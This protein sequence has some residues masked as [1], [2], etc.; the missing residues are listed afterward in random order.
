M[1]V[2]TELVRESPV[3]G[4]AD[5]WRVLIEQTVSGGG[6][7]V[8]LRVSSIKSVERGDIS[9]RDDRSYGFRVPFL[10]PSDLVSLCGWNGRDRWALE[11]CG[12][13]ML[14]RRGVMVAGLIQEDLPALWRVSK[15]WSSGGGGG[16]GGVHWR[17]TSHGFVDM[18]EICTHIRDGRGYRHEHL[19]LRGRI[20]SS[21]GADLGS[22]DQR[23]GWRHRW[24]N[25]WTA[26]A[27]HTQWLLRM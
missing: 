16:G 5:V 2:C 27:E 4:A 12:G 17:P 26:A 9:C 6:S 11:D 25:R 19:V 14:Q 22:V 21:Q 10:G 23:W 20:W 7:L 13:W 15:V 3:L 1:M 8:G 24:E 18:T